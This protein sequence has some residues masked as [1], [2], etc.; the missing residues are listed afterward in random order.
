MATNLAWIYSL[1]RRQ[2]EAIALYRKVLEFDP[3]TPVTHYSLGLAYEQ[4][5]TFGPAI[6]EFEK[7]LVNNDRCDDCLAHLGHAYAVSGKPDEARR[8]LSEL[9]ERA[10]HHHVDECNLAVIYTGLGERDKA[11]EWLEKAYQERSEV[12]L[13]L[14]VE[15]RYDPIRADPRFVNLMRRIGLPL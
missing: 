3:D 8:I 15:P 14:K 7:A 1:A 4:K 13:M 12:V 6:A 11:F 9:L 10:A 5:R 2:N